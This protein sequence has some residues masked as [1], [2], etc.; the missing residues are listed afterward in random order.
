MQPCAPLE[1]LG[2]VTPLITKGEIITPQLH[3]LL[4]LSCVSLLILDLR[5][6]RQYSDD[7]ITWRQFVQLHYAAVPRPFYPGKNKLKPING[8]HIVSNSN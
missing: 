8:M 1:S 5:S 6:E 7:H 4:P 2:L 3:T